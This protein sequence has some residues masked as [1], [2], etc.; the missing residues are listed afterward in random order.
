HRVDP[1]VPIEEVAGTLGELTRE[2]KVR[3]AGLSEAGPETIRRA[4]AVHPIA[5]LQ[6]EYSLWSRDPETNGV[7]ETCRS[8]GGGVVPHRPLP[9]AGGRVRALHPAVARVPDRRDR[10][11]IRHVERRLAA[12]EPALP[13]RGVREEPGAGRARQASRRREGL[14]ARAARAGLGPGA[15]KR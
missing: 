4:H 13:G 10:E 15:G 14:H 8:L 2:G 5:A 12:H 7:L 6:S 1:R 11:A 3:A 9:A